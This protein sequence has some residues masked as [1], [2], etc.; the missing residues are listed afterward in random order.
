MPAAANCL[1]PAPR[2]RRQS[3]PPASTWRRGSAALRGS[4]Q[5]A[6]R[7]PISPGSGS[8]RRTTTSGWRTP[9]YDDYWAAV[10]VEAQWEQVT[11]PALVTGAW[12]DLFHMGSVR[13]FSGMRSAAGSAAARAGSMLV[14]TGGGGHGQEGALRFGA[15]G[16]RDLRALRLRILRPP[17][18]GRGQRH[19]PRAARAVVRAGAAGQRRRGDR[20]LDGRRCVSAGRRRDAAL[21]P[22]QRRR[23]ERPLGRRRAAAR[24]AAPRPRRQLHVRPPAVPCRRWA[25]GCAA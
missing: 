2:R 20:I 1:P 4:G 19:G 18:E 24:P 23:G 21:Q 9:D 15:E 22:G 17:R 14:M 12:G 3:A 11:V 7:W 5:A 6:C 10:D 16:E 13:A 25:A 8:W